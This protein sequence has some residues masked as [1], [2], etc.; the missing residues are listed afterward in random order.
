MTSRSYFFAALALSLAWACS[1][2]E[3]PPPGVGNPNGGSPSSGGSGARGGTGGSSG[4]DD[5]GGGGAPEGGVGGAAQ[6]GASGTGGPGGAGGEDEGGSSG[7]SGSAGYPTCP[8]DTDPGDPP[9]NGALCAPGNGWSA[10]TDLPLMDGA[11]QLVSITPDELTIVWVGIFDMVEHFYLADRANTGV[12]FDSGQELAFDNYVALSPDGLRL[13]TLTEAGEFMELVRSARG[14]MFAAPAEGTFSTLDANARTNGLVFL[15]AAI[16]PDDLTLYYLESDG[17]D[18]QPLRISK[19]TGTGPWPVGT[20]ISA[21]EFQS[22][23]GALRQP[24]GVSADGL[25]L[26][27]NDFVRSMSRAAWREVPDGPFVWFENLGTRGRPQPNQDCS[28]L[29]FTATTGPSFAD[30]D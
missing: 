5:G 29:Y 24:T 17:Q 3:K 27:F 16:S 25:T 26:Y 12:S 7:S 4:T 15:G 8:S 19:R 11:S 6:G 2:E 14:E 23:G 9:D 21:C 22:Y 13:V 28:R 30:A 10:V 20:A 1:E 18:D